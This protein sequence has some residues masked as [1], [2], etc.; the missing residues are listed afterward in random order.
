VN[1][2]NIGMVMYEEIIR[3]SRNS[4]FALLN[5]VFH[6]DSKGQNYDLKVSLSKE[7]DNNLNTTVENEW[8]QEYH[9]IYHSYILDGTDTEQP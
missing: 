7:S 2:N 5:V 9:I 1:Y 8:M 4:F 3:S 6:E